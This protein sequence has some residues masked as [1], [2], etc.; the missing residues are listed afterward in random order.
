MNAIPRVFPGEWVDIGETQ[1]VA[2]A[3][4]L[5]LPNAIEV[6]YRDRGT[7]VHAYAIWEDDRW[8]LT[9]CGAGPADG[10]ARY[11]ECVAALRAGR[12]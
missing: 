4:D 9:G 12:G 6:V 5:D 11:S 3:V 2:C 10:R 8:Q 1:A 7:S